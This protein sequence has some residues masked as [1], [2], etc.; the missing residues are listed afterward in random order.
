MEISPRNIGSGPASGDRFLE[1]I[2]LPVK[3]P[4]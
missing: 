1:S 2:A 3:N 4:F